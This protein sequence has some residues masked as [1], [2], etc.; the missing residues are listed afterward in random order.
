MYYLFPLFECLMMTVLIIIYVLFYQGA[1]VLLDRAEL[2]KRSQLLEMQSHQ[3]RELQEYMKQSQR[4]RHDFRQSVHILSA[5]AEKNDI[6]GVRTHLSEYEQLLNK[7]VPPSYCANAALNALFGH[8]HELAEAEGIRT[9]WKIELPDP[10]TFSELDMA[11]LFGN[12]MENAIQACIGLPE[13]K[14]YFNLTTEIRHGN[15][16]YVV[17]TNSFD[18]NVL[19][20]GDSAYRSTKHGGQGTGLA[21]IAAVAEKYDGSARVYNS[22]TEFFVDVVL[23]I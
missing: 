2:E 7:S 10:L 11:A 12:I 9:D 22:D 13:E 17:S 21:S 19:K 8:Y 15:S 4:L 1:A 16:L 23:K 5:L 18:G 3:Y 6:D 20:S 14:R